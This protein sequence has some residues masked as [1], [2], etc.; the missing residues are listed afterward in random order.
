[1]APTPLTPELPQTGLI[2]G[3][4]PLTINYFRRLQL[5][6]FSRVQSGAVGLKND[7]R[8]H[9]QVETFYCPYE[10]Q[11]LE[12]SGILIVKIWRASIVQRKVIPLVA[13][14]GGNTTEQGPSPLQ[15]KYGCGKYHSFFGGEDGEKRPHK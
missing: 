3:N 5:D 10:G 15:S 9:G 7:A 2:P 14:N 11:Y 6:R 8:C 4:L 13:R 12:K 1:M